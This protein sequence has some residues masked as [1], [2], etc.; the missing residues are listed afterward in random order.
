MNAIIIG[1]GIVGQ[2]TALTLKDNIKVQ[3][4][5]PPKKLN[6]DFSI[7]DVIFICC[8]SH[9]VSYYVRKLSKH[10]RVY[11]RSTIK[12]EIVKDTEIAVYP[13][14]L[15]ESRWKKDALN[16]LCFIFGGS[17][18]QLKVLK[19]FSKLTFKN[20]YLTDNRTA[21]LMKIVTNAYTSSKIMFFNHVYEVCAK[22]EMN[23][24]E[25]RKGV[26]TDPRIHEN[27]TFVPGPD[28]QLGFGGKCFPKD[29]QYLLDLLDNS[30]LQCILN[31]NN[32]IREKK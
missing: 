7:A 31:T 4:Y 19:Q 11:V 25:V 27:G 3:W 21:A 10:P 26:I 29:T 9:E 5:D 12:P 32:K 30:V 20:E 6:A 28:G 14:F 24:E 1:K 13:E 18:E 15:T 8:P 17:E 16:P 22:L 2:A 23:Y